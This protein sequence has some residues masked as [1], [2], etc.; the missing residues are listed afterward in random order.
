MNR[1]RSDDLEI[2]LDVNKEP[3]M[4]GSL[5]LATSASDALVLQ[6]YEEAD[7]VKAGFGHKLSRKNWEQ[8]SR[9]KDVYGDVLFTA[10]VVAVNVAHPLLKVMSDPSMIS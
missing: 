4:R 3:A 1:F 6:Y 7:P 8:V 9:I 2:L 5:K 10:P